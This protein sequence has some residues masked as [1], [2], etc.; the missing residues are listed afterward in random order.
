MTFNRYFVTSSYA[1]LAM[2]FMMLVATGQLGLLM[3]LIFMGSLAVGWL[4]DI[5]R[6][7]WSMPVEATKW[8]VLAY[9]PLA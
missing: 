1:L 4:I 6:I 5:G 9:L 3:I 7:S 8:L 2:S